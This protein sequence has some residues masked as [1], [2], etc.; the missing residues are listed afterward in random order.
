[1][2][3]AGGEFGSYC[4]GPSLALLL[5]EQVLDEKVQPKAKA[6]ALEHSFDGGK[7][8]YQV[9]DLRSCF[10]DRFRAIRSLTH[11]MDVETAFQVDTHDPSDGDVV[12]D[13]QGSNAVGVLGAHKKL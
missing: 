5:Q 4:H 6:A 2:G 12:V 7:Q 3:Q 9:G 1:M 11:N 13:E 8:D 10:F